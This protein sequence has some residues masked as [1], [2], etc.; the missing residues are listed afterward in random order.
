M[1]AGIL[2]LHLPI[3]ETSIE[4]FWQQQP[5]PFSAN[6]I[7]WMASLNQ[8]C[9]DALLPWI[10]EVH[11]PKAR[12]W[13][14]PAAL[15]GIWEVVNGSAID[16]DH[17]RLVIM[18]TAAADFDEL[19]VPQEWADLPSWAGDYY[20]SVYVNP[21]DQEIRV[22][23]YATHLMLKQ[24]GHYDVY[25]RT[26]SL[27]SDRLIGD[28]N[29]LWTALRLCAG[30]VRQATIAPLPALS[31]EQA[32]SLTERLGVASVLVPRLA[33]PFQQWGALLEHDGW[34]QRLYQRR[35]GLADAWSV[36]QWLQTGISDLAQQFGWGSMD[37]QPN[38]ARGANGAASVLVRHLT[39]AGKLYEFCISQQSQE[40]WRFALQSASIGGLVPGGFKL[41]LLTE[42]LM[43]FENNE[44]IAKSAI[45]Q[46]YL[47][48]R[49]SPG[50]TLIWEIEPLPDDY[51]RE[52][53]RF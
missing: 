22:L 43:P 52:I 34:R 50:D 26:Y 14:N 23:G 28:F 2:Q 42:D 49:L 13:K 38:L 33:V 21:D 29:V 12:V 4:R 16:F 8:I 11:A 37:L 3:P 10:Q 6:G 51:A 46:L 17:Q 41:R 47:E 7:R 20:V 15:P 48:V 30:E 18:P 5:S 39:I 35:L 27:E 53:L 31:Q 45:E 36:Q 32:D 9:L 25:D 1:I 44:D 40:V 19:R 24:Q